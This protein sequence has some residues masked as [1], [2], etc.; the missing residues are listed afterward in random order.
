MARTSFFFILPTALLCA[1]VL[2]GAEPSGEAAAPA[3]PAVSSP[4]PN[5]NSTAGTGRTGRRGGQFLE[6]LKEQYP[7]EVAEIEALRASDLDSANAKMRELMNKAGFPRGGMRGQRTAPGAERETAAEPDEATLTKLKE[8][9]PEEFARYEEWKKSDPAKA[10]EKLRELL[11]K[12]GWNGAAPEPNSQSYLRDRARREV[13]R[14]EQELRRRDPE[15]YRKLEELRESDP[16]AARREFRRMAAAAGLTGRQT[17]ERD[18][19]QYEYTRPAANSGNN[20]GNRFGGGG[21]G[22]FGPGGMPPWGGGQ[23]N[24]GNWRGRQ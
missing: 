3:A 22:G 11:T 23:P 16:D 15:G 19:V 1:A 2:S 17:P 18:R 10:R 4:S 14:V 24:G 13:E 20:N 21:F 7:G 12:A 5:G 8:K 9:F 6:R